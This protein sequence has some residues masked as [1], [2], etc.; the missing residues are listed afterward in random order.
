[1]KVLIAEDENDTAVLYK[2]TLEKKNNEIITSN[3]DEN[4]LEIYHKEF[5]D[6]KKEHVQFNIYNHWMQ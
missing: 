6:L 3:N 4:C 5:Q 2:D 1:M